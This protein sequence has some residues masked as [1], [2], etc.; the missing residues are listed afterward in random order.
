MMKLQDNVSVTRD[1]YF[2]VRYPSQLHTLGQYML[3][4]V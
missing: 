3:H 2:K 4:L 1:I